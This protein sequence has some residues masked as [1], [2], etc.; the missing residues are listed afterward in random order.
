M[1]RNRIHASSS[2]TW[3]ALAAEVRADRV[4][5]ER[6]EALAQVDAHAAPEWKQLAYEAVRNV[7]RRRASFISDDVWALTDLP[8][9]R[10]D[11]ALGPVFRKAA[12]D[13]LIRKT[14][15]T[16]PSVRSHLSGKPV[17]ESLIYEGRAAA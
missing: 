17:W 12:H 4:V 11:R 13:G 16:R 7:A 2:D 6:D 14:D 10:E 3:D 1:R 5:A 9:A 15:R 8:P